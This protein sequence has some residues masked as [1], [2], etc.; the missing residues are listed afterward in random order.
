MKLKLVDLQREYELKSAQMLAMANAADTGAKNSD[1]SPQISMTAEQLGEFKTRQAELDGIATQMESLQQA[2]LAIKNAQI[3]KPITRLMD[4]GAQKATKSFGQM[5]VGAKEFAN[6]HN[7]KSC[8]FKLD[9]VDVKT[10][11]QTSAGYAPANPRTDIV[12]LSAQRRPVVADLIP[13]DSTEL[14]AI[15]YMLETTFTNAAA[16][17]S[18][19]AQYAESALAYTE[20]TALVQKIATFLPVTDEQLDDVPGLEALINQRMGLMLALTEE[21]Q[22]LSGSGTPPDIYGFLNAS[23]LQTQAQSTDNTHDAILKA[24]TKVRFTGYAEPT[25]VIMHPTDWQN[26][27]LT[28]TADGLYL[29]GPPAESGIE[30]IWGKPIIV[31]PAIT[32][33]T[34][35]CGDFTMYSHLS[36]R[37]GVEVDISNSHSDYFIKGKLAIRIQERISL[38]IYRPSAFCSITGITAS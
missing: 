11:M 5:F 36:R 30:R 15:K 3:G 7:R 16:T 35:L 22:L 10:L 24:F 27:R 29:W 26:L 23:G 34:A 28:K 13:Q 32:A 19:G 17:A 31:T 37:K 14:S 12:V 25:G 33:G 21:T 6:P 4:D 2:E 1:G 9:D 20:Q 38:E 18:E 8:S